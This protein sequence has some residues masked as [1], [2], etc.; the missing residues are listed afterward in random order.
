MDNI[1]FRKPMNHYSNHPSQDIL[2]FDICIPNNKNL[3]KIIFELELK[4]DSV[5]NCLL[6]VK[7]KIL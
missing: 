7:I 5:H 1:F 4:Y 6:A 3:A 2:C